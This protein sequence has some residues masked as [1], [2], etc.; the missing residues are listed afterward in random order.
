[1]G[2]SHDRGP[3]AARRARGETQAYRT[4]AQRI[5]DPRARDRAGAHGDPGRRRVGLAH[6]SRGGGR[7]HRRRHGPD[8]AP[9]AAHGHPA[10]RRPLPHAAS[11]A[12][13]R[14]GRRPRDRADA[15]D[16]HRRSG[17]AADDARRL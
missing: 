5:V 11:H 17:A 14:A 13:Q 8:D 6:A 9:R 16:L 3:T 15:L 7:V 2:Q 12:A 4:P 1:D 10:R